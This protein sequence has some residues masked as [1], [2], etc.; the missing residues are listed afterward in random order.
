MCDFTDKFVV[1][2]CCTNFLED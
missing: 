2:L 1:T